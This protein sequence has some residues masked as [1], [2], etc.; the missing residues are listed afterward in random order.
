MKRFFAVLMTVLFLGATGVVLAD[1]A[2][3]TTAAPATTDA[4]PMKK[5]KHAKHA[6]K[7]KKAKTEA[8][9]APASTP[10]AK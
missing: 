4:K 10:A 8:A 1:E 2:A 5:A 9:A 7:M 3:G 6:K